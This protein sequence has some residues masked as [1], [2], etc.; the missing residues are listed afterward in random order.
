MSLNEFLI[1]NVMFGFLDNNITI[2]LFF[3]DEFINIP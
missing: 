1:G 3:H 2:D